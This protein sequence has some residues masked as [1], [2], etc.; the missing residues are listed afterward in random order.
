[1]TLSE[2]PSVKRFRERAAAL[3]T[4][5]PANLDAHELRDLCLHAGAD[6]VGFVEVDR[7]ELGPERDDTTRNS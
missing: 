4:G 7:P 2:H 1:M 6:D 3:P 5:P